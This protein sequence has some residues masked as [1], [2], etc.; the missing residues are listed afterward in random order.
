MNYPALS[1]PPDLYIPQRGELRVFID[2]EYW[3]RRRQ[4]ILQHNDDVPHYLLL[5]EIRRLL[6]HIK[7]DNFRFL[8]STLWNTGARISEALALTRESF[9][10]DGYRSQVAVPNGK[11]RK[12][13]GRPKKS[14]KSKVRSVGLVN[15]EYVEQVQRYLSTTKPAKG[16]LLFPFTRQTVDK[17]LKALQAELQF[18][19]KTMSA[20]VFR[21]SY[22]INLLLQ[23]RGIGVIQE[24]LGHEDLE[25]TQIY[26]K[27]I[28][29]ETNHLLYGMQY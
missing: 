11:L 3:D 29:G 22:A 25:T 18:P 15:L 21:H 5:P 4:F 19:I 17:R 13:P 10:L 7:D 23:G 2:W 6:D 9:Y 26:L 14:N 27:I 16:E 12:G 28:A 24:L 20:H 1:L 8:V